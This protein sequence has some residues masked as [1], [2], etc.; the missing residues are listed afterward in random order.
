[1]I[2][3]IITQIGMSYNQHADGRISPETW[4]SVELSL[5]NF[6]SAPGVRVWWKKVGKGVFVNSDSNFA[7]HLDG[8]VRK[9]E[10]T[11]DQPTAGADS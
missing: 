4:A 5:D 11:P 7:Q 3:L 9:R 1:M 10:P 8:M 2:G 6:V